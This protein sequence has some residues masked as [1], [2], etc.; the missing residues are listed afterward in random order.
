MAALLEVR[1]L[2]VEYATK[3]STI[4]AVRHLNLDLRAGELYAL[5]GESGSGKTTVALALLGILAHPGTMTG[6][7]VRLAGEDLSTLDEG[8]LREIRG[9][10]I[11]M[12]F[13][14]PVAGLNPVVEVGKQV[15]EVISSHRQVEPSVARE[16][17]LEALG[18]MRL[19]DPARIAKAYPGELSGGMCQRV[20]IAIATVLRPKVLIA[21]EPTSALDVTVQAQILEEL[22]QLQREQGTAILL[23][24]HDLGVVAQVADRV[25][26]MYAGALV[27][28][29]DYRSVFASPR[30]PYT[31]ALLS[32]LPRLNAPRRGVLPQIRGNPPDMGALTEQCSFLE[33]C[34]KALTQCRTDAA[35]DLQQVPGAAEGEHLVACYNMVAEG[36]V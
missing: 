22:R 35:P 26:I 5:V 17:T 15:E 28:S 12:I 32:T 36:V 31:W 19:P 1:D 23:I 6:G 9:E 20:M 33:R 7:T 3:E 10:A 30:H 24:T 29:T 27:E 8:R 16:M 2:S 11:S 25:G 18:Q 14:D 21:D 4:E 13:Q 34:P